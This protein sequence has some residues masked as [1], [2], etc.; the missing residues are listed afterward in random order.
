MMLPKFDIPEEFS[1]P[2]EY[3]CKLAKDGL[4]RLGLEGSVSHRER[5]D[6]ELSD[7]KLIWDTRRYD[8]TTYF[9]IVEDIMRFAKRNGIAAGIRGSGYGSLLLKCLGIV[10][11]IIDPVSYELL[12]ERFLG[13]SEKLFISDDD[14]GIKN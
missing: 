7:I 6:L 3:L 14:F 2:Y 1:N 10:E 11:T 8:F 12:W 9:L 13:F 5:L 4:K